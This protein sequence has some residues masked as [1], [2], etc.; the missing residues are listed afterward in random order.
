MEK[1]RHALFRARLIFDDYTE[2]VEGTMYWYEADNE[3]DDGRW[4]E[5]GE[6]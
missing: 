1:L 5:T 4:L 3:K 6:R 2:V